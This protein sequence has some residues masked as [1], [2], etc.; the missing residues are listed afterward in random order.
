[1]N[2]NGNATH[3]TSSIVTMT[4]LAGLLVWAGC[5]E[6]ESGGTHEPTFRH[7]SAVS[8]CGGFGEVVH[9]DS[10][11]TYCE[12]ELLRWTYDAATRQLE[13]DHDRLLLNC[14]GEHSTELELV[15]GV[16]VLTEIDE[17]E[18]GGGRC[19]CM[20][21]FDYS[22]V[23]DDL[24]A[25]EIDLAIVLDVT[26]DAAPVQTWTGTLDLTLGDGEIVISNEDVGMW[27]EEL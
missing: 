2:L 5:N 15:D 10:D 6:T 20:C 13:I 26:D 14:C 21:V 16:Y 27:C 8:D 24:D 9:D 11:S 22:V 1:M 25:D 4:A 19:D 3:W 23:V 17:P 7:T 18:A 12:S